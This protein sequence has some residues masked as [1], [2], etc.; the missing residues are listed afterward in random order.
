MRL[1][2]LA[3]SL[4]FILGCNK[5]ETYTKNLHIYKL[6]NE[7]KNC[8]TVIELNTSNKTIKSIYSTCVLKENLL[9]TSKEIKKLISFFKLNKEFKKSKSIKITLL[10]DDISFPNLLIYISKNKK[11]DNSIMDYQR[12]NVLKNISNE[13]YTKL[14]NFIVQSN[15]YSDFFKDLS[16]KSCHLKITPKAYLEDNILYT[17]PKTY[18]FELLKLRG[19]LNTNNLKQEYPAL[20]Y[21]PISLDCK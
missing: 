17:V 15:L 14:G 21:I 12:D 6:L 10:K 3:F 18:D 20:D 4:F 5:G 13:Y 2:C 16:P 1:Y 9:T 11:W 19:I 8:N 7:K